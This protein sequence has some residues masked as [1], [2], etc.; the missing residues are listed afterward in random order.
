MYY[1]SGLASTGSYSV[2]VY[3][4]FEMG[5]GVMPP[6]TLGW[7]VDAPLAPTFELPL[8]ISCQASCDARKTIT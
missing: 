3:A 6:Y 7:G 2:C 4:P 5:G 8:P 1:V